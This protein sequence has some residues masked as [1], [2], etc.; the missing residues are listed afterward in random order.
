MNKILFWLCVLGLLVY[1]QQNNWF[2]PIGDFFGMIKS[3]IEYQKNLMPEDEPEIDDGGILT[4]EKGEK[5]VVR[6]SA[7]G[8]VYSGQ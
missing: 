5:K 2:K 3:D 6:R 7:L 1:A 8:R 4:L